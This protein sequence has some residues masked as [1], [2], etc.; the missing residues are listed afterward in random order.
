MRVVEE[1]IFHPSESLR[2]LHLEL[3][4]FSG[5]MHRHSHV[6]LTW[7][8]HGEGLRSIGSSVE[9]FLDGDMVLVGP[10][11]PHMWSSAHQHAGRRHA[12]TVVQFSSQLVTQAGLPELARLQPLV[13]AAGRGLSIGEPCRSKVVAMLRRMHDADS[14][15]R[16]ACLIEILGCLVAHPPALRPIANTQSGPADRKD[17]GMEEAR[18]IDRVLAWIHRHFARELTVADAARMVHVTPAAFS[19]LFKREIG[20]NFTGY[21]NDVRCSEAQLRLLHSNKPVALVA[22][23]CGF[24][25]TSHFNKQFL[26]R[27]GTTPRA[28]R[29]SHATR[30]HR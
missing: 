22:G 14:I 9:P 6:E 21:V 4:A 29:Q 25:T 12:A 11:V 20:K 7:V 23:E 15:T 28:Y 19:R 13:Q 3:E 18:R 30:Q 24:T 8:E 17:A 1:Y 2:V 5:A 26:L 10:R 16:L 27:T